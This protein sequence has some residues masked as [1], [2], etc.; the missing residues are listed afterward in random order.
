MGT[1][2]VP[3]GMVSKAKSRG[4]Y[5]VLITLALLV[6]AA[7]AMVSD[8]ERM[9][10]AMML[11]VLVG[12][13]G[14]IWVRSSFGNVAYVLSLATLLGF[15]VSHP[16]TSPAELAARYNLLAVTFIAQLFVFGYA[17]AFRQLQRRNVEQQQ[18]IEQRLTE[19]AELTRSVSAD[20]N[21]CVSRLGE[22]LRSAE[23]TASRIAP[24]RAHAPD[25]R[26]SEAANG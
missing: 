26:R 15:W 14:A 18:R 10:P 22:E 4:L 20:S 5:A 12:P 8:V 19:R 16:A 9:P 3:T 11:L 2:S 21:R 24:L 25:R 6:I 13:F 17:S 23:H 7:Q 1:P